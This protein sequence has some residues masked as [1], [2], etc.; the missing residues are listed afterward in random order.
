VA[1][2]G[3]GSETAEGTRT[4]DHAAAQASTHASTHTSVT[5]D[6]QEPVDVDRL[7]QVLEAHAEGLVRA[8]GVLRAADGT[9][10]DVQLAGG[11]VTSRPAP[12]GPTAPEVPAGPHAAAT[13]P[14]GPHDAA[15]GSAG[16]HDA[17]TGSAL[18]LIAAGPHAQQALQRA[19][20]DLEARNET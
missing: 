18:V 5:V 15:A 10:I 14:A 6:L 3:R 19:A 1:G 2:S 13:S 17:A 20:H 8:K 7:V 4:S 11:V 16:P 12:E 9:R